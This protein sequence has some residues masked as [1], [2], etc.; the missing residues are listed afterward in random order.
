MS[1]CQTELYGSSVFLFVALDLDAGFGWSGVVVAAGTSASPDLAFRD[2]SPEELM[3]GPRCKSNG[4]LVLA[5]HNISTNI[6][7]L[8]TVNFHTGIVGAAMAQQSDTTTS[9]GRQSRTQ[10]TALN[11]SSLNSTITFVHDHHR[12][13]HD[14]QVFYLD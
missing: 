5:C 13:N 14:N 11:V 3:V 1:V 6:D 7:G 2:R 8:S 4:N 9:S 12:K 10:G